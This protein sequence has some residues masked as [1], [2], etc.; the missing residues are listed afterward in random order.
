MRANALLNSSINQRLFTD[1]FKHRVERFINRF[2]RDLLAC[3]LARYSRSADWPHVHARACITVR[4]EIVV[5]VPQLFQTR[6]ALINQF[7]LGPRLRK[8]ALSQLALA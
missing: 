1:L 7:W 3:K 5:D 4:E 6:Y 2:S 8:Q